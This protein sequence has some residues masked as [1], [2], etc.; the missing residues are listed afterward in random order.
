MAE[1]VGVVGAGALGSMLALKLA[2]AGHAVVALARS[3]ARRSALAADAPHGLSVERDAAALRPASLLFLCVKARDTEEAA[4]GLSALAPR[5]PGVCS[6][7][8]GWDHMAVL[9]EALPGAPLIAGATSLGAYFDEAGFLQA[10]LEGQTLLAPWGDTE[11]R[12]AEY[13][14]TVLESAGLRAEARENARQILWRK[15]ALNAAVNPLTALLDRENGALLQNPA[16]GRL[17]RAA[18][19]EAA[20]VGARRG[21]LP[22]GYDPAP[23]LERLLGET[24]GNRSSM[25]EDLARGRP[26]EAGAILGPILRAAREEGMETPVIAALAELLRA[27]EA[28]RGE[29]PP[30]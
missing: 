5:F 14:A 18:A 24:R 22:E 4:R 28:E 9:E 8:N 11:A 12:W 2:R 1:S 23:R 17:A 27:A 19:R 3:E 15:L 29:T 30:A 7:Q 16:L 20:A 10:S 21:Y 26:T 13:A 6:L 25:A